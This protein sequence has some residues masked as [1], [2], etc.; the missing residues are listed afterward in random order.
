MTL[1]LKRV[2]R[3][4]LSKKVLTSLS[5]LFMP[6]LAMAAADVVEAPQEFNPSAWDWNT[7][8]TLSLILLVILVIARAF[9]IGSLTEKISGKRIVSS[10]KINAWIGIVFLVLGLIG[11]WYEMVY[12]GKYV[13]VGNAA[14]EHGATYDSMFMW[15]FGFTFVVF[16]VTEVLLFYFMFRYSYREDR[17]A[18]YYFHNNKLEVIWTIVPAI[19]LT[20]LVLRGFNTWSKITSADNEDAQEIEVFAYQFGWKARYAGADGKFGDN[21]FTFI[22]GT[23]PL[24]LAVEGSVDELT[25]SLNDEIAALEAL[26]ASA[27]DS[28]AVWKARL[29]N[30]EAQGRQRAYPEEYKKIREMAMDAESGAY[31]RGLEKEIKRKSTNVK[32]IAKFRSDEN[33]FNK[34]GYDDKVVTE[35]VLVK[36]QP[37]VFK[38]RARDVIHSAYMPEFRAQMNCVPGM[39]TQFAFTPIKTTDEARTEKGNPEYDYYLYCNKICGAAHYN[40]KIKI[41][42]VD[43]QAQYESWLAQQAPVV[44]PVEAPAAPEAPEAPAAPE[45]PAVAIN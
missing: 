23:N 14:S 31:V 32:R 6:L 8:L 40:M 29:V 22:S 17:K 37:Y 33:M 3:N 41:T 13:M 5:L 9:D 26:V 10:H 28:A 30:F 1:F 21:S 11:V 35:I 43:N 16:I 12:H 24:G 39:N 25:Q 27:D 42:V 45:T 19:V 4:S 2:L 38:F 18:L 7:I 44:A 34:A 36:N 20:F 15:T